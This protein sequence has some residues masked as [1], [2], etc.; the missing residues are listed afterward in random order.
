MLVHQSNNK[1]LKVL[2]LYPSCV[3]PYYI[4]CNTHLHAYCYKL[5]LQQSCYQNSS[6]T[7]NLTFYKNVI[8]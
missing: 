7:V 3:N 6:V 8:F 1:D 2:I 4:D 5:T